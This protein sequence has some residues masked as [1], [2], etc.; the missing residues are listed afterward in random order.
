VAES[1][2]QYAFLQSSASVDAHHAGC[3]QTISNI[4]IGASYKVTFWMARRNGDVGG[5]VPEPVGLTANGTA[6]FTPTAPPNDTVWHSYASA[7]FVATATTYTFVFSTEPPK[8]G[9]DASS[10]LDNIQLV[11]L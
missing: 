9:Q 1:G 8:G 11:P 4:K 5:N 10:L 2:R 3:S 7:V 6:I